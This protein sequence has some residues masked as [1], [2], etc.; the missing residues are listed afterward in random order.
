[1]DKCKSSKNMVYLVDATAFCYRAFYALRGLNTSYGQP[2]NAIY[3]FINMLNKLI[4]ER[5]PKYLAI[6]FDVSRDTFR[7]R[8]YTEYKLT[9]PSMP[10]ALSGQIP[11]IKEVIKAY[12]FTYFEKEG[13]EADDII[14]TLAERLKG[15]GLSVTIVSS[16]KDVLQLVDERIVALNP[17]RDKD[18]LYSRKEVFERY[19][20]EPSRLI[21]IFA[22]MG[23]EVDNVPGVPGVGEKTAIELIKDFKSLDNLTKNIEKIK[24]ASL[25]TAIKASLDNITLS[26]ELVKLDVDVPI[27]FELED[28]KVKSPDYKELYRIFKKFEFKR[29][30]QDLPIADQTDSNIRTGMEL[31]NIKDFIKNIENNEV[32]VSCDYQTGNT[33]FC[34]N[35]GAYYNADIKKAASILM[36]PN[37]KKIGYDLKKLTL[38]FKDKGTQISG[39]C[40]DTMIAA[41]LIDPSKSDYSLESIAWDYLV[42]ALKKIDAQAASD[43]IA[44]LRPILE[45]ALKEKSLDG[46]FYNIEMPLIDILVEMESNGVSVDIDI[47]KALSKD[48]ESKLIKLVEDIYAQSGQEFN[49]NSPKQLRDVLFEKLKLPVIKRIKSGPSTDEDVLRQLTSHHKLPILLLEY[50][51]LMKLKSTYID[52]LP[53]LVNPKTGRIHASFSQVAT[54]TGRLACSQPNLQN[55]PI[56]NEIGKEIRRAIVASGG[57]KSYLISADY[58]QIE[59]RLLAQFSKDETLIDAFKNDKDIHK[60]TASLIYDI[61]EFEVTDQMRELAKRINFSIVYGLSPYGL[62]RDL[63]IPQEQARAFIESYFLRYPR[64]KE[65]LQ[66][67]IDKARKEGFVTT[68]LGRR[69]YIPDIDNKN[70]SIRSFAERQAINTPIQGSAADLI[71]LAMIN[72]HEAINRKGFHSKLI[73]QI[74]DE[75]LFEVIPEEGDASIKLIRDKMENVYKLDVP[76]K[77]DVAIGKNWSRMLPFNKELLRDPEVF[78]E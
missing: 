2:T 54:G 13:F 3:G 64:V 7:Q 33:L 51:R 65:Y 8:R 29:L 22:L 6:C 52:T 60:A 9:R 15:L 34:T 35:K 74:H 39:L 61:D 20:V 50:R 67:Q 66:T 73:L 46:L 49:I 57:S 24:S 75:L 38:F 42:L 16:D 41:Y 44:R 59:L 30:L 17:Y 28:L 69:R 76:I 68:I 14:A 27:I 70:A 62:S 1:M 5:N 31:D 77:V 55:I 21:D 18:Q 56:K 43:I 26:R 78:L 10:D 48:I 45:Q 23:D 11:F 37:L 25:R 4:K 36:D 40:F 12:N 53:A 32:I 58:S 72:I 47:L 19:G 71:K 63:E